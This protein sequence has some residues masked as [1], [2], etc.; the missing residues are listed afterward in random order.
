MGYDIQKADMW[1]R[2][3]AGL[4]DFILI[5]ILCVAIMMGMSWALQYDRYEKGLETCKDK[6]EAKYSEKYIE[7]YG[8]NYDILGMSEASFKALSEDKQ[9]EKLKS[10]N[11]F[12]MTEETIDKLSQTDKENIQ[13]LYDEANKD[14]SKDGEVAYFYTMTLNLS[15]ITI[16]F[17]ILISHILLELVVPLIFGNGQT[18]GKKIFGIGIVRSDSV[19]VSFLQMFIRTILGKCTVET[20]VPAM[21]ILM[22]VFGISSPVDLVLLAALPIAQVII[23]F[24]SRDKTLLHDLMAHTVAVDVA[25]QRIFSS[26]EDLLEYKKRIQAERAEKADY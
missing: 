10:F 21:L 3:S 19:K 17:G 7:L 11:I 18:L 13:K 8:V 15:L 24:V 5:G 26:A 25:S 9:A 12:D 4:F 14:I 20:L 2:I 16:I 23:Y 22:V 6:Y 1:K